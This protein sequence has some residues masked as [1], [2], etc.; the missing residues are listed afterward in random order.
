[1][2]RRRAALATFGKR[3]GGWAN[4]DRRLLGE[5]GA[6]DRCSIATTTSNC[7]IAAVHGEGRASSRGPAAGYLGARKSSRQNLSTY[8]GRMEVTFQ[9]SFWVA[10]GPAALMKEK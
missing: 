7:S 2:T 4:S 6:A 3:G 10:S 9:K 1:M 5:A 8:S